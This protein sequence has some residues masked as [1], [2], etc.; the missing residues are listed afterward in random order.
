M[1]PILIPITPAYT[2]IAQKMAKFLN[3]LLALTNFLL[4]FGIIIQ[5][6]F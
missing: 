6:R 1:Q 2:A 3:S 5:K 4:E